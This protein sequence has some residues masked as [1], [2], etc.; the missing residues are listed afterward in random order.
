MHTASQNYAR[1]LRLGGL[2]CVSKASFSK[3]TDCFTHIDVETRRAAHKVSNDKQETSKTLRVFRNR[4]NVT[5]KNWR[6]C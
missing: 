3:A 4:V 6:G 1:A 5:N 2:C